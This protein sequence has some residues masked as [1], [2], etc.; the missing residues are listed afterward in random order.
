MIA[1][2]RVRTLRDRIVKTL[3]EERMSIKVRNATDRMTKA[4]S[5]SISRLDDESKRIREEEDKKSQEENQSWIN[6]QQTV[7]SLSNAFE[8]DGAGVRIARMF[9]NNL[10]A[11]LKGGTGT[12]SPRNP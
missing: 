3:R 5:E 6:Q 2:S 8:G 9:G 10:E 12:P 7:A 4:L 1:E 11:V